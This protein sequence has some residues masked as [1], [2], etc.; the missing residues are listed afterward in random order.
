MI[1]GIWYF[2]KK[3]SELIYRPIGIAPV[4][5]SLDEEDEDFG[6]CSGGG[7]ILFIE[8]FLMNQM[9]K[10]QMVMDFLMKMKHDIDADGTDPAIADTDG[11]GVNDGIENKM[12]YN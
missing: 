9:V 6:G 1:K 4:A 7:Q 3:Y 8:E 5:K 12:G 11:D 2:D 10:I